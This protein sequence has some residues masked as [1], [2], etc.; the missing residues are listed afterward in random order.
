VRDP[1]RIFASATIVGSIVLHHASI[2]SAAGVSSAKS[3]FDGSNGV[4]TW[5]IFGFTEGSDVGLAGERA[6]F[7][8]AFLRASG[9]Q[10]GFRALDNSLGIAYAPTD[11]FV[12][13]IGGVAT[14][15]TGGQAQA[16]A[17][18]GSYHAVGI[19]A[20][21]KYQFLSR[22]ESPFGVSLQVSP[23]WQPIGNGPAEIRSGEL[24]GIIDRALG[25]GWYSALN[26]AVQPER[27][28][29]N[30]G[31]SAYSTTV[32]I[33]GAITHQLGGDVFL[34]GELRAL[35]KT[36]TA[37]FWDAGTRSLH[38]GPTLFVQL[39]ASGYLGLSWSV[40]IASDVNPA[41]GSDLALERHHVRL[42]SGFS[43]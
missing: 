34:G 19:T 8:D 12:V 3:R 20:G 25:G 1:A 29:G 41:G 24:R 28:T 32:E 21:A 5:V 31:F 9:R 30:Q 16:D 26:V 39:G 35:K 40:Q 38:L 15:E 7:Q 2:A 14:F 22:Q 42:K 13:W 10:D 23:S 4:N 43:F 17:D 36:D 18:L 11:R 33:S 6:L 37:R 27:E